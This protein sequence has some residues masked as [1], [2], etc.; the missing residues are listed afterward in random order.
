MSEYKVSKE[1][2]WEMN[3]MDF[4]KLIAFKNLEAQKEKYLIDNNRH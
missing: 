3:Q 2:A 1:Q 4:C